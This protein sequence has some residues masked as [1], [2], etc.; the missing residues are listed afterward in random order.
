MADY[1]TYH[2]N[3][4][5]DMESYERLAAAIIRQAYEDYIDALKRVQTFRSQVSSRN[6]VRMLERLIA[7]DIA[8]RKKKTLKWGYEHLGLVGEEEILVMTTD[9]ERRL[10]S[11][12]RWFHSD[13]FLVLSRN[14]P[15]QVLINRACEVVDNWLN[16][17]THRTQPK[18]FYHK[19][20]K[21]VE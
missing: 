21:D 20:G 18:K 19:R 1:I 15:P 4:N 14:V 7:E 3:V 5:Y 12:T 11:L 9:A 17:K 8:F 6:R 16:D 13:S 10:E 2:E